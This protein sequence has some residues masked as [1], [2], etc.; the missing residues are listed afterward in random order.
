MNQTCRQLAD[1][2]QSCRKR[3]GKFVSVTG[4]GGK[5][6]LIRILS[7]YFSEFVHAG[8]AA[9]TKMFLPDDEWKNT[10][11][12]H[13]Y[14]TNIL[15]NGK[16]AGFDVNLQARAASECDIIFIEADGSAGKP[17]KGWA[18]FEPVILPCSNLTIGILPMNVL[19]M[20][21]SEDIV[22]RFPL[23]QEAT[24]CRKGDPVDENCYRK[25]IHGGLFRDSEHRVLFLNRCE[26][27]AQ[28]KAAQRIL[29][30]NREFLEASVFGTLFSGEEGKYD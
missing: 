21:V 27:L 19:G 15:Q 13:F 30:E 12:L 26:N 18:G 5:T 24:G 25:L 2:V 22:F 3:G 10:A 28:C 23:F 29:D 20:P 14:A 4:C 7:R 1:I 9:S 17:L 16:M 8:V 11:C 6:S